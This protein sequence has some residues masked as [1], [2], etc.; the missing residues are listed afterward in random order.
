MLRL[1]NSSRQNPS[2]WESVLPPEFFRINEEL[3]KIDKLLGDERFF[4]PFRDKFYTRMGRPAIAVATSLRMCSTSGKM[5]HF[6]E[7]S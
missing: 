7:S 4:A 5:G 1:G 6:Q 3:A 2:L